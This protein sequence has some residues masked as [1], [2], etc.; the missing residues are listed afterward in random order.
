[1]LIMSLA[2]MVTATV[3]VKQVQKMK[4]MT[5]VS[6]DGHYEQWRRLS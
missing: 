5:P 2:L 3:V 1:V 6:A 4:Q